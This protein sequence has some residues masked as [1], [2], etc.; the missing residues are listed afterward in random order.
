MSSETPATGSV[1]HVSD[2][3]PADTASP[4]SERDLA[5]V[6][7]EASWFTLEIGRAHV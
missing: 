6:E 1:E 7:F 5:I 3:S 2:T 4:L